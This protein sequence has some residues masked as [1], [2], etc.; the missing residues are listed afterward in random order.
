M[1]ATGIAALALAAV[2]A[3]CTTGEGPPA[4]VL[5]AAPAG[6]ASETRAGP[7]SLPTLLGAYPECRAEL[8]GLVGLAKLAGQFGESWTVFEGA[9]D[10]MMQRAAEC[11]TDEDGDGADGL[12]KT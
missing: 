11:M 6:A 9:I 5:A 10:D 2:I 7:E 3:G 1:R 12:I 4:R 8:L